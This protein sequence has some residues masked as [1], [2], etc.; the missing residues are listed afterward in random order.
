[1]TRGF[2]VSMLKVSVKPGQGE[3]REAE[4]SARWRSAPQ[5]Y[6]G[7]W[8]VTRLGESGRSMF[9][10]PWSLLGGAHRLRGEA[11]PLPWGA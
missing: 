11:Q 5:E 1:M 3:E 6:G 2:L 7:P 10:Y 9:C 8:Q 4:E